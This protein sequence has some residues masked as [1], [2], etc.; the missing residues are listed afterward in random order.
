MKRNTLNKLIAVLCLLALFSCKSRK[1]LMVD[2]KPDTANAK[3]S[4]VLKN[5]VVTG[6]TS[7][8]ASTAVVKPSV[9]TKTPL[10]SYKLDKLRAIR[11]KQVDFVTFSGKAQAK[12]SIDGSSH[13]VTFNIR[14]KKNQQIWVSITAVLGV[15]VARALI[16]PDSIKVMNRLESTYLKKPFSF[17]Y[18]YTSK[19]VNYQT[20]EALLIG[21]AVPN[22]LKDDTSVK[23]D[24][25]NIVING[26][27]Q[28]LVYQLNIGADLRVSRTAMS[29][30]AAQQSLQVDNS[31]FIQAGTKVIPSKINIDSRA[32]AKSIQAELHYTKADFDQNLTY[33]FSVPTRFGIV[34]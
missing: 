30:G 10:D 8:A 26:E 23:P 20:L 25:G 19:Q 29:N 33:P 22:L 28:Q 1:H 6:T 13:D 5:P 16:T 3:D 2:R 4:V 11:L 12:L 14:I 34:K 21:N 32:G 9:I 17:V 27:L 24:N 15:E 18:Q 7:V 31:A